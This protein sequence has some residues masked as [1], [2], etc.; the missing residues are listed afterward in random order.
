MLIGI[1]FD[2]TLICYDGVFHT[3]ATES[4]FLI[5]GERTTKNELRSAARLSKEGDIAWQRI[6]AEAYGP[7]IWAAHPAE[8]CLA[9]L[10]RCG[11]EKIAVRVISHK[12]EFATQDVSST[13]LRQ[14]ALDWM[15]T[16]GFFG[17]DSPLEAHHCL[18]ADTRQD[19]IAQ[20]VQEG[21]TYFI[22]DL[23]ETFQEPTF[24]LNVHGIFYDPHMNST[25][26]PPNIQI[27]NS[28]KEIER[29]VFG[30]TP[31]ATGHGD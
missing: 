14:A 1:D 5:P 26:V 19:K 11:M 3:L 25:Q 9:F 16:N 20:I 13:N 6:Q 2:N 23:E 24:P 31:M 4:E 28:W 8:G 29:I 7:R 10:A 12:T 17:S 30:P 27:T 15:E 22:D 21:C 18:F